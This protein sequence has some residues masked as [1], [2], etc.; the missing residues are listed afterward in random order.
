MRL[1]FL[2]FIHLLFYASQAQVLKID[3]KAD[4]LLIA[5]T[6]ERMNAESDTW[7]DGRRNPNTAN[8]EITYSPDKRFKILVSVG[9]SC[10]AYCNPYNESTLYFASK[11]N[12]TPQKIDLRFDPVKE[13]HILATTKT[14]TD[15]LVI[16][17]N[18]ARPRG[19]ESGLTWNFHLLRFENDSIREIPLSGAPGMDDISSFYSIEVICKKKEKE[20]LWFDGK[21]KSI[22]YAFYSYDEAENKCKYTTGKYVYSKGKIKRVVNVSVNA[23]MENN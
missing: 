10:G 17:H 13:I 2:F 1:I 12:T 11:K 16:T 23:E 6:V 5:S 14:Y 9:E 21:K 7:D 20:G 3:K 19:I 4:S 15:Y 18:W 8:A 22:S